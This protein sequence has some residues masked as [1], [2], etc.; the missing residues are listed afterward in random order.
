MN[1]ICVTESELAQWVSRKYLDTLATR[2]FKDINT[3]SPVVFY[4]G[5]YLK[6]EDAR[7]RIIVNL[8][9]TWK[10]SNGITDNLHIAEVVSIP[11]NEIIEIA[12]SMDQHANKL[13]A[14]YRLPIASWSAEKGWDTWLF[15][16][17]IL[18][19]KRAIVSETG[20]AGCLEKELLKNQALLTEIIK[21]SL[22]PVKNA[23]N[24]NLLE[25]WTIIFEKR[26]E[27]IQF[28]RV[29]GHLEN[30]SMF[31][32]S[33]VQVSTEISGQSQTFSFNLHNEDRNWNFEDTNRHILEELELFDLEKDLKIPPLFCVAAYL[34]LYDEIQIANKNWREIFN[35]IRFTK[36]SVNSHHADIMLVSLLSSLKAEEIYKTCISTIYMT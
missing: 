28:L 24:S 34:R 13:A 11:I 7:G 35:L 2:V 29:N 31:L 4:G 5:P 8:K 18:E 14:T 33:L 20:R 21:N 32:A 16:Q 22:R 19:I 1:L 26:D 12:P 36:F 30:T 3:L 15:N 9:D 25:G 10:E 6:Q 17:A 23:T 27:W